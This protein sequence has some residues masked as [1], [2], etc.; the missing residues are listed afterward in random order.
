MN[1]GLE[2]SRWVYKF[3]VCIIVV[4]ILM[5]HDSLLGQIRI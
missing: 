4:F 1:R 5:Y 2:M 3:Y